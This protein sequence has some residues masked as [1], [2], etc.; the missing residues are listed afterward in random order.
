MSVLLAKERILKLIQAWDKKQIKSWSMPELL[1]QLLNDSRTIDEM[2]KQCVKQ[3]EQAANLAVQKK[4]EEQAAQSFTPYWNFS[5]I[6]DEEVLLIAWERFSKIKHAFTDKQYQPEEIQE[7]M[8]KFLED[9]RN[10]NEE[11]SE[12][13]NS[14]SWDRPVI[15]DDKEHSIQFKL[16]LENSSKAIASILPTEEPEYSLSMRD[17]HLSTISEMKSNEVIKSSVKNLI[18]IPSKSEIT[19]D[20]KSECD[21][22]V[23]DESFLIFMTFS[24]PLFNC[25]DD[26]TSND[27]ESLSNEDVPKEN[28]KIYLNPL[29]DDKEIISTKI[30]PHYFNAESNLLESLLNQDTLIDYSPKFDYL[31]EIA[32]INPILPGIEEG[33]L[34]AEIVDTIFESL[35]PSPIPVEDGDSLMEEIDLFLT[36]GDLMPPD[37]E[38]DNY[39]SEGDVNFLEELLSNNFFPSQNESF[40]FDHYDKPSFPRPPPK[41]PDVEIFFNFEPDSGELISV[42]MNN[43]DELNEDECFDPEGGEIDVFTKVKDDDYFPFIFFIR[44]FLPYL[45]Y[46]EISPLLLITRSKDTIFNPGIST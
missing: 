41:P 15:V 35:S 16:Y 45:I 14:L 33:E 36:T 6:D 26:F 43:I 3:R 30:D 18:P 11:L 2:L 42:V 23:N 12:F 7:L 44:I 4:Q 1:L 28:F 37:I 20:N 10:I 17:K 8:C 27:D 22:P 24:N 38:S 19:F 34:N 40:N 13:T 25:N 39:D 9:V 46:P 32:H 31:L 29:F 5:M 21:V